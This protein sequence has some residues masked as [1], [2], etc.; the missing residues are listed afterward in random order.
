MLAFIRETSA[1]F[2]VGE[3]Y[4]KLLPSGD[5][6]Q[7][8]HD[9]LRKLGPTSLPT[10]R[11]SLTGRLV[12]GTRGKFPFWVGSLMCSSEMLPPSPG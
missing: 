12:R 8:T 1:F 10:G 11:V 3:I 4:V 6:V 9:P 5:A 2:G 7:L